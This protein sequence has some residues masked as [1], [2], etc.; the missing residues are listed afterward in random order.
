MM[1]V[2]VIRPRGDSDG[3]EAAGNETASGTVS[4]K[5]TDNSFSGSGIVNLCE[6]SKSWPLACYYHD[7][8]SKQLILRKLEELEMKWLWTKIRLTCV[9][10]L[11]H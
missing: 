11:G 8:I 7:K 2:M 5:R 10:T 9:Q 4:D 1:A 6:K 3:E